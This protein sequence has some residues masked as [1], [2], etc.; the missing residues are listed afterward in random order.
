MSQR[1]LYA[2]LGVAL[3]PC[4]AFAG[5]IVPQEPGARPLVLR[6][7]R[8]H[9]EV[10]DQVARAT[11]D[12]VFE[13][14]SEQTLEGNYLL[15]LPPGAA[16]SGFATWIDGKRVESKVEEKASAR[17]QYEDARA[18][19]EKPAMLEVEAA[20]RFRTRV[21]GIAAHG[22][23]RVEASFAQILPYDAGLVSLRL[24]LE[25]E[26]QTGA[27]PV[28]DFGISLDVSDQ[29]RITRL[30][31]LS[32]PARVERLPTG[33]YRVTLEGKN[34][35]PGKELVLNYRTESSRLGLSFI[36][37]KPQGDEGYFLLLASPQELTT[38]A[39]IV[40]KDVVFVF[41]TSGSMQQEN[42]IDQARAALK[43]CLSS[44]NPEDRFGVVAFS[45]G[46]NPFAAELSPASPEK[47]E[48]A[49]RFADGLYANG[50]TN[51]RD[52]MVRGLLMLG[53]SERPKVMLMMTDGQPTIGET[54]PDAISRAVQERN[55]ASARVFTFGVGSDVN[56]T[57]LERLGKENRGGVDFVAGGQSIDAVVGGFYARISK[58]VLSD[59]SFDFGAVTTAFQYPDVLPDLYKGSQ[60]VVVGRYRGF[61]KVSAKLNGTLNGQ[62][63]SIPFEAEFPASAP[64]DA[65]VARLWAQKRIDFLL[66]QSRLQGEQAEAKDEVIRLSKAY[67]IITPYTSMVAVRQAPLVASVTP[68]RV[69][70]GDPEV[71]VGAPHDA[72][73]LITLP[74]FGL[75]PRARWSEERG[76][77][78]A[79][80]LVPPGT[81]DGTYPIRIEIIYADGSR[82]LLAE[83][84]AIDTAAPAFLATAAGVRAGQP[85]FL[86]AV[87]VASPFELVASL[88]GR[89]DAAEAAK[90]LFD[91]RRIT[92]RLW[93]GREVALRLEPGTHGFSGLADTNSGLPPGRYPVVFTAQDFAGNSAQRTAL[94]EVR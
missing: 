47:L 45:D 43:R 7:Q 17:E 5:V 13:N 71:A 88:A 22:T 83:R 38:G 68:S 42:K 56:R 37:F 79:R 48:Q 74:S 27:E 23:R 24:P 30:E 91:V 72:K 16:I 61:G 65:F 39:D 10:R 78:V 80:F 75:S 15:P 87:A 4:P 93:D 44:L 32:H 29:K 81:P 46:M 11:V 55:K 20:N 70:P 18:A 82:R 54:N 31:V 67:Q 19:G 2:L 58:P 50:G 1:I 36:P 73:V 8:I 92:A 34:V 69:K 33:A 59:L 14:L 40:H 86:H 85:L 89:G 94:V 21:S 9:V 77:W 3:L 84:I 52:A 53:S 76:L 49:Q 63:V 62:K 35:V 60:L 26:G 51:I 12:E 41:D 6:K 66:S 90:A 25:V 57:L 28:G 64:R